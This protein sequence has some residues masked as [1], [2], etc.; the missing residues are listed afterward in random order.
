MAKQRRVPNKE[1]AKAEKTVLPVLCDDPEHR[2]V[3][4]GRFV[5]GYKGTGPRKWKFY[6]D[7]DVRQHMLRALAMLNQADWYLDNMPPDS[8]DPAYGFLRLL[9]N[10]QPHQ[11]AASEQMLATLVEKSIKSLDD[12]SGQHAG[13]NVNIV[14]IPPGMVLPPHLMGAANVREHKALPSPDSEDG[15][16][17]DVE[18]AEDEWEDDFK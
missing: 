16:A 3:K 15:E 6:V 5:P 17:I 9:H 13:G 1:R 11:M 8:L 2:D 7:K 4:T 12:S 18:L 10:P 14:Q